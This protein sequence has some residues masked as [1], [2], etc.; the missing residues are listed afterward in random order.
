MALHKVLKIIAII[1]GIIGC[2]YLGMVIGK[3]DEAI[4][5]AAKVGDTKIVGGFLYVA[6]VIAAITLL[7]VLV[8]VL[9]ALATGDI[10][11]TF[12]PIG[13]FLL[14][15]L[16]SYIIADGTPIQ[17]RE[18]DSLSAGGAKWVDTGLFVFYITAAIAI[19]SMILSSFKK[20]GR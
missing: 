2:V 9:R 6:Y 3:G 19:L 7:L 20:V 5:A 10:K 15:I 16:I 13:V 14:I 8:F 11:R 4:E 18:G 17:L 1:L 12:I